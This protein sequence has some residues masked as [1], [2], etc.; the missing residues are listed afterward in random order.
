MLF[1]VIIAAY[2]FISTQEETST[3]RIVEEAFK[4]SEV[5][6][7]AVWNGMMI[8]DREGIKKIIKA[9]SLQ[10]GF[11]EINIYDSKGTLHYTS[12]S[13]LDRDSYGASDNSL[14]KDIATDPNLRH[15]FSA[16]GN[17]LY[18][19]NPILN[20]KSCSTAECHAHPESQKI[21]GALDIKLGLDAVKAEKAANSRKTAIFG[22]ALFLFMTTVSGL[23]VVFLVIP[24]IRKLQENAGKLARGEYNPLHQNHGS[25]E[26]ADL[27]RTFDNMSRQINQRTAELE[28]SRKMYRSLFEEVP[29]YLTMIS[30]EYRILR[31]NRAFSE[32]FGGLVGQNCF[33]GYKGLSSRCQDC[34]V[35]RTFSDGLSHQSEEVWQVGGKKAYVMVKTSP[36]FDDNGKVSEVLEMAVNVTQLRRFQEILAKTQK[37]YKDLFNS[38]P[39]YLAVVDRDFNVIR[40]NSQFERDFGV[41]PGRKCYSCY[42]GL[43]SKCEVC[44]VEKT[45]LDGQIHQSEEIWRQNGRETHILVYTSPL[46]DENGEIVAVLEMCTNVTEIKRLQSDLMILGET[47]AGM[48]HTVKNI[49]SGLHGG[50]YV[51]D[52]GLQRHSEERVRTGWT[53]VKNNVQKISDLVKGILYAAKDREPEYKECDPGRLLSEVCEL[54]QEK[55]LQDKIVITRNFAPEMGPCLLDPSGI[56]SAISNL[57]SNAIEACEPEENGGEHHITVSAQYKGGRLIITVEDDGRGMPGEVTTNIFSKFYSTKGSRGTGLGLV[58][59]RKIVEEHQGTIMVVSEV[60]KGSTFAIDIPANRPQEVA[61]AQSAGAEAN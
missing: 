14:L 34:P 57:I 3:R 35:E 8:N 5:V 33:S 49:L 11:R 12:K 51:L 52:S 15:K 37:E 28:A 6:K 50:I 10:E 36:I 40:T 55:A 18:I 54:F 26:M 1:A 29:C 16:D 39:C 47:I 17:S 43:D 23:A 42:K 9:I 46:R 56:H 27:I 61:K 41:G 31:A 32:E 58:I 25:D 30:P 38:V 60:G 21:L 19:V 2:H 4:D 48:S 24:H 7:S 20:E 45:F 13:K 22:A 53:M 59:T 44:P